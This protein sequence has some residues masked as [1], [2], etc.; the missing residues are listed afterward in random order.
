MGC[1]RHDLGDRNA[2]APMAVDIQF[3]H[4][5]SEFLADEST[6]RAM[7]AASESGRPAVE[8]ISSDLLRH[9]GDL[10]RPNPVKQ[11]IGRLV[12]PIM[13]SHGFEPH[14]R[15][16]PAKSALFT[17]GTVYRRESEPIVAVLER[18]GIHVAVDVLRREVRNAADS[19]AGD[20]PFVARD[21]RIDWSRLLTAPD[22]YE[23]QQQP[24]G[25]LLRAFAATLDH[26]LREQERRRSAAVPNNQL[27]VQQR[28]CLQLDKFRRE[29]RNQHLA[30]R[31]R[32]ALKL[33][34][35]CATG[36]T[37]PETARLLRLDQRVVSDLVKRGLLYSASATP[38]V[39]TRLP[40]FQFDAHGLV[41]KVQKVLPVLDPA[42]HPVG[43]FN[44]FTSPNPDLALEQTR[45]APTSPRDWLLRH[46]SSE[47]VC[48]LAAAVAVG[49]PT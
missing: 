23:L 18:H 1:V 13:E 9:F 16:R 25:E 39:P 2:V 5:L 44:W 46:Y 10:V 42:I 7:V 30:P 37:L 12:R 29:Q 35:L 19:V 34:A 6:V 21:R 47:P 27:T 38:V 15:R 41:P 31:V 24:F 40:L 36:F 22:A 11:R 3:E 43:V 14:K 32:T 33:G 49:T 48:R 26:E 45:F 20:P 17:A 8:A 28:R 4:A